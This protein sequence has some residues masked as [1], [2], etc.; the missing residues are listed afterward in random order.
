MPKERSPVTAPILGDNRPRVTSLL[1]RAEGR[2]LEPSNPS[3]TVVMRRGLGLAREPSQ[4]GKGSLARS[5]APRGSDTKG[6]GEMSMRSFGVVCAAI[7]T[8]LVLGLV[9]SARAAS[10]PL[11]NSMAA[12][13]DSISQA[14]DV[15]CWYGDHPGKSWSTGDDQGDSILSHY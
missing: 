10:P 1:R 15:C 12:I 4:G 14:A 13:G 8:L 2:A 11:P 7:A 5:Q 6:G 9:P 3:S